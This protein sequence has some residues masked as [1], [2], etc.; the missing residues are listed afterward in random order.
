M[1]AITRR[2]IA[3]SA[4]SPGRRT[5][6]AH[7]PAAMV[8]R[9]IEEAMAMAK[10]AI[11]LNIEAKSG[12]EAEVEALLGEAAELA[13]AEDGTRSWY[14]FRSGPSTFGIFDTFDD[15]A[16]RDAHLG[17]R[18]LALLVARTEELLARPPQVVGMDVV[19]AK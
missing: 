19:A 8:P 10:L 3:A 4:A 2:T 1:A 16:A 18:V 13:R 7:R 15:A 14:A 9:A 11:L 5:P 17:G 6:G 12:K